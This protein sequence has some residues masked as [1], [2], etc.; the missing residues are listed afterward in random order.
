MKAPYLIQI[1]FFILTL[2]FSWG[3]APKKMYYWGTYEDGIYSTY[4]KPGNISVPEE[5]QSLEL[6]IEK[7]SANGKSVPPGLHAHLGYLYATEGNQDAA[8]SH[9]E[10]EK[11]KFPE[12]TVFID[13]LIE[14]MKQQK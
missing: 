11:I 3:C 7:A 5:I 12:S 1:G 8:V 13:G 14:R 9:F 2:T 6:Q 4:L 10:I